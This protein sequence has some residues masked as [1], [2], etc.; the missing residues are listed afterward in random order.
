[1]LEPGIALNPNNPQPTP[2]VRTLGQIVQIRGAG[3]ENQ[4]RQQQIVQNQRAM[5][6]Q[7]KQAADDAEAA[8]RLQFILNGGKRPGTAP[9][10]GNPGL[11]PAVKPDPGSIDPDFERPLPPGADN[12]DPG[13]IRPIPPGAQNIDPGFERQGTP[14]NPTGVPPS[15]LGGQPGQPKLPDPEDLVWAVGPERAQKII[16]GIQALGAAKRKD[17]TDKQAII[18]DAFGF[19]DALPSPEQRANA[20]AA[21]R[22]AL[23]SGGVLSETDLPPQY[24]EA[25]WQRTKKTATAPT[26]LEG[27][28]LAAFRA[29]DTAKVNQIL[30]LKKKEAE[31]TRAPEKPPA[32]PAVVQEYEYYADQERKA[33]RKPLEFNAY[34]SMD[35]NRKRSTTVLSGMNRMYDET[36]PKAIAEAIMRGEREPDTG[37]LG[38]P[39][40]GAVDSYLAAKGFDKSRALREWKAQIKLGAT[41]NGSQQVRLDESIR[42]GLAMYDKIDSLASAWDGNGW[43]ALSRANLSAARNGVYG[44]KAQQQAIELTGA[45]GQLTSDVATIEQGGLTPTN[46]SRAIAEKS[47]QDW[48]GNGTIQ[49]MTEQ[50]RWMMQVRHAA[51]QTQETMTPGNNPS[52]APANPATPGSPAPAGTASTVRMRGPDGNV[53]DVPAANVAAAQAKGG[54]IIR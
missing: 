12:I 20:Y 6:A 35:A 17:Y 21:S 23:V 48:W 24:D 43:G 37:N 2:L 31:A 36:N 51:R 27:E 42:S 4:Q 14:A 13:M 22:D 5:D 9:A 49:K 15:P 29:G 53:Y 40:S 32:P 16:T 3:L 30:E 7:Q 54:V 41:M 25:W 52:T 38:R 11:P 8:K 50:G 39:V 44:K 34:Q 47:L 19:M 46:E 1:M 33:G 28:L 45:I 10:Q 18:R 26:N